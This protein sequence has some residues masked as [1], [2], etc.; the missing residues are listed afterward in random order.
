M[1]RMHTKTNI[2]PAAAYAN[3]LSTEQKGS[4]VIVY[5]P[6]LCFQLCN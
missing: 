1:R 5:M 4:G 2:A 3:Y 6:S